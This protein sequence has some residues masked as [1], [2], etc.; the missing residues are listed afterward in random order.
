M[1]P[2]P[3][4]IQVARTDDLVRADDLMPLAHEVKGSNGTV[5]A[6]VYGLL[7]LEPVASGSSKSPSKT[8]NN[9]HERNRPTGSSKPAEITR[10][11]RIC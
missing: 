11:V 6:S 3:S 5:R 8:L 10:F 2:N 9:P 7:L 4:Q 1:A